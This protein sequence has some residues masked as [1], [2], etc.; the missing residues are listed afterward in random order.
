[1]GIRRASFD[2]YLALRPHMILEWESGKGNDWQPIL[3]RELVRSAPGL[4]PPALE[5]EFAIALQ[6]GAAPLPER[7]SVFGVSTLPPFYTQFFQDL[8]QVREV[9]LFVLRPTA[10]WFGDI[11]SEREE[12]RARIRAGQSSDAVGACRAPPPGSCVPTAA[13]E[14]KSGGRGTTDAQGPASR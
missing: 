6:R 4:H 10:E 2:Q 11:R 9:H 14:G 7:V 1:M 5:K 3:W 8:A 13:P 12:I